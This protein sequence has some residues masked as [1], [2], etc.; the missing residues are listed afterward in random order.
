MPEKID[1]LRDSPDEERSF[2]IREII[3]KVDELVEAVNDVNKILER[4][5]YK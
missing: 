2:S 1:K 5:G 3:I 4:E